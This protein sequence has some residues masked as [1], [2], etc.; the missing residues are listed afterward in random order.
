MWKLSIEDDQGQSTVVHL[1]RGEYSIGRTDENSIRLTERN[2][3]RRH[4]R[5]LKRGAAWF[6]DDVGSYNGCFVNGARVVDH[7]PVSVGDLVQIGD[8]RLELLADEDVA[9]APTQAPRARRA[10]TMSTTLNLAAQ[11]DRLV[12]VVGPTPGREYM[13]AHA[14]QRI[15]R[16]E[17]C[18][19]CVNHSSV[20]RWHADLQYLGSSR[21][22]LIDHGSSN[23]VRINGAEL[24]RGLLDARDLVELGDVV[25]K[26]IPAGQVYRPTPDESRQLAAL[27]GVALDGE[28][29]G[30]ID[31]VSFAWRSLSGISRWAMVLLGF[32]FIALLTVSLMGKRLRPDINLE[33][34]ARLAQQDQQTLRQAAM[35]LEQGNVIAAHELALSIPATSNLRQASGFATIESR[36]AEE[37]LRKANA[38]TLVEERRALLNAVAQATTVAPETRRE[39]AEALANLTTRA[40][41][42]E[43]LPSPSASSSGTENPADTRSDGDA[44]VVA[45]AQP[46]PVDLDAPPTIATSRTARRTNAGR[47]SGASEDSMR[48]TSAS[49]PGKSAV[50]SS[51]QEPNAAEPAASGNLESMKAARDVLRRKVSSGMATE[52]DLRVLRSLCR[53]LGDTTCPR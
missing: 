43:A 23:G 19:I 1:V 41:D 34:A 31:H 7:H 48:S 30:D 37:Q 3:S 6:L 36:W 22:E 27:L 13:L 15:G 17:E 53:Q 20:S 25:L 18:D 39:A 26:Y 8:Y 29:P 33:S 44:V 14:A 50:G 5:L 51:A 24:R 28:E 52:K 9:I 11:T 46:S 4:A 35:L 45:T 21:Y 32:A 2:I 49:S 16:G 12:M 40:E 42:A 10:D 38:S 47:G